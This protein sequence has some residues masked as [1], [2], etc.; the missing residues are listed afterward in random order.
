MH[1]N[2]ICL[3]TTDGQFMMAPSTKKTTNSTRPCSIQGINYDV[4]YVTDLDKK[5][6]AIAR[7][8]TLSN[9][10][11]LW[12]LYLKDSPIKDIIH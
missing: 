4:D 12:D 6:V 8:L 10:S 7:A 11:Q 2:I 5:A 1:A 9:T 3:V